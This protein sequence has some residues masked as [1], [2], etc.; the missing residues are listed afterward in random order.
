MYI[1]YIYIY[2][3]IWRNIKVNYRFINRIQHPVVRYKNLASTK[4]L[5]TTLTFSKVKIERQEKQQKSTKVLSF[6]KYI[7][8]ITPTCAIYYNH[9]ALWAMTLMLSDYKSNRTLIGML[10][11]ILIIIIYIYIISLCNN[12]IAYITHTHVTL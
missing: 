3:P 11:H 6:E 2:I 5:K 9:L 12:I 10:E 4:P 8:H 7:N 1:L